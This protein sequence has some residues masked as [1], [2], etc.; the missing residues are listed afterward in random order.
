MVSNVVFKK[1]FRIGGRVPSS[2]CTPKLQELNMSYFVPEVLGY[3]Q[4]V[5]N[6]Y[7]LKIQYIKITLSLE[8]FM[9]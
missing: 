9:T 5:L 7:V 4:I 3:L 6:L 1:F 8:F 2:L